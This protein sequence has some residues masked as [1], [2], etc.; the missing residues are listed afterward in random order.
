[1]RRKAFNRSKA[2]Q[3]TEGPIARQLIRFAMP[4]L[5]GSLIQQLY[6]TVDLMFVGKLI[7]PEASAAVGSSGLMVT[8]IVGL[9]SG[10]SVGVGV[11]TGQAAGRR[12]SIALE[13]IIHTAAGFTAFAA[14]VL[15][16]LGQ[17]L[18]GPVLKAMHTPER[19]M[20]EAMG[21]I[22]IY[23]IGL[24]A[25]VTYN[26]GSG[27][28]RALGNSRSPTL[29]QL[30]GGIANVLIDALFIA[31]LKW[32][33]RGAA[34]TTVCTQTLAAGLALRHLCTMEAPCCLR[35]RRARIEGAAFRSILAVGIPAAIQSIVITLSNLVVQANINLL[36]VDRIAAFTAYFKVENFVYYPIMALGAACATFVSQNAGAAKID[37]TRMGIRVSLWLGV[38]IT[39][40]LAG[41]GLLMG[42]TLFGLFTSDE[43]VIALGLSIIR[44][45]FPAY[46]IYVFLE[47]LSG[48]IRGAGKA[49][50]VMLIILFN[51]CFVRIGAL[52]AIMAWTPAIDRIA[53][54][55]PII[56]IS[57]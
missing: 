8:C 24:P 43:T 27:M 17:L 15:T 56:L 39:V 1:M 22:R 46:F 40:I 7:G 14:L 49:L 45:T 30:M 9:F 38:S 54:V 52:K 12:D 26:V 31:L 3:L 51:M 18:A 36:G 21:Y 28:I 35:I 23:L 10:L 33:M 34:L 19:I 4:L 47:S 37:R 25:I 29:Y 50:P 44:V 48:A 41:L 20:P 32:G 6:S 13:S 55:Y 2:I 57:D 16:L 42:R 5:L 53:L 11:V